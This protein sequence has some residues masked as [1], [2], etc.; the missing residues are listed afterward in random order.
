MKTREDIEWQWERELEMEVE[1]IARG[2]L[3]RPTDYALYLDNTFMVAYKNIEEIEEYL[4]RYFM[5]N[6]E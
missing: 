4:E 1:I 6:G 5:V 2:W 3:E